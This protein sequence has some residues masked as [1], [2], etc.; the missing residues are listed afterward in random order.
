MQQIQK[1]IKSYLEERGWLDD[2]VSGYAKSI[3]IEAAE[4][5]EHFQWN[6]PTRQEAKNDPEKLEKI[7]KEI[8]DVVIY[9][10]DLAVQ[11]DIDVESAVRAK[12]D[13]NRKKY[14]VDLVKGKS[15]MVKKIQEEWRKKGIN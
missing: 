6:N 12:L 1:E 15:H 11:L 5:L 4:L 7:R 14:P 8:A 13:H 10:I 2:N 9:S 3:A